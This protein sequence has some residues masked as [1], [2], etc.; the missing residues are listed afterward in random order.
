MKSGSHLVDIGKSSTCGN[1]AIDSWRTQN[2]SP[3]KL[4]LNNCFVTL[5]MDRH[6][7]ILTIHVNKKNSFDNSY[8][9]GGIGKKERI[10]SKKK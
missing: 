3:Q 5:E 8:K 6:V 4:V 10:K 1:S 7:I 9:D 2:Q